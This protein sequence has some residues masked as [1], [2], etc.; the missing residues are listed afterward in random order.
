MAFNVADFKAEIAKHGLARTN[1]FMV[2]VNPPK[3]LNSASDSLF[4]RNPNSGVMET[5][6]DAN[7][8]ARMMQMLCDTATLPGKS[9]DVIEYKPQGFGK[10]SKMPTGNVTFDPLNLTFMMDSR[11]RVKYFY[12][13][14]LQEIVN[15]GSDTKGENA[16]YKNRTSYEMN[17][18]DNYATQINLS[19]FADDT[20]E[21]I[22]EFGERAAPGNAFKNVLTYQ[23]YDCYPIQIGG[24][25][26]GWEQNDQIARLPVEFTY[27]SYDVFQEKVQYEVAD[28]RGISFFQEI[29]RLGSVAGVINSLERP[30]SVQ[31]AIN[32][33]T[34]LDNLFGN[35]TRIF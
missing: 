14:W 32:Q 19:F 26:V 25:A 35:L 29:G 34:R 20:D 12:E 9:L 7:A 27:S 8:D 11:H 13:L 31:D 2:Q 17:Y 6:V 21:S 15:T 1:K 30:R 3:A 33:F 5:T 16:S 24:V 18:K 23:F 4:Q 10:I 28:S 22:N